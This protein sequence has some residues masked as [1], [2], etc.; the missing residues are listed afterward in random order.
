MT[1]TSSI[2]S[3]ELTKLLSSGIGS[4]SF[5]SYEGYS[6]DVML[7]ELC[8]PPSD[9]NNGP[10]SLSDLQATF[11]SAIEQLLAHRDVIS[12]KL[13]DVDKQNKKIAAKFHD[14]LREPEKLLHLISAEMDE[15]EYRFTKVSSSAVVI[16]DRLAIIDKEK[17][18][19]RETD[20]LLEAILLLNAPSTTTV[21]SST[22]Q[23]YTTLKD[24]H[25][26]HEALG[27][28][29]KLRDFADELSS[30][31]TAVAV[32]EIHR[33]NQALETALLQGFSDAQDQ[34]L[35]GVANSQ[36]MDAMK[37]NAASLLAH[38][39]NDLVADRFVWNV[40]KEKLTKHA[41]FLRADDS[42]A[43]LPASSHPSD[44][45]LQDLDSLTAKVRAIV[46]SQ[47]AVIHRV[48]PGAVA[49]SVREVLIERVC[50]DPAF[51]LLSHLERLLGGNGMSDKEYVATLSV[52]Y[53][54]CCGLVQSIGSFPLDTPAESDR[55]RTFLTVQLQVLFGGHR[56]RYVQIEQDLLGQGFDK[57][58]SMIKWPPIPSGKNKYKLKEQAAKETAK[59]HQITSPTSGNIPSNTT[60]LTSP[61]S[62]T[63][64]AS[65]RDAAPAN[66]PEPLNLFY[67]MLLPISMDDTMPRK[68]G[69]DLQESTARCDVVLRNSELRVELMARLYTSYCHAFGDEYL[70]KMANLSHELVQEP[71]LCLESASNFFVVNGL[72]KGDFV[73]NKQVQTQS[74]ACTQVVQYL[75][76][77][78][79]HACAALDDVGGVSNRTQFVSNV[80]ATFKD[81][82]IAH[83]QKFKFD[84]DGACLLLTDLA[85]YRQA[86][87]V[88]RHPSIDDHFDLLHAIANIYALPRDSLVSYVTEGLQTTLGKATL[89]AL[90]RR[91]WDYNLNGDK[92]PI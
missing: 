75:S 7:D 44:D 74:K 24:P 90:I 21:K 82:Y 35:R 16:G 62:T 73:G 1:S 64:L 39:C 84:A 67:Q 36:D 20:E 60:S 68:F 37:Q 66:K 31:S 46:K 80:C 79:M 86:F 61:A 41:Q 27:I 14:S 51:G 47:F 25:K 70:G 42:A 12:A 83:L 87:R 8:G 53:E 48:F 69:R 77:M 55:M 50:H 91:R 57:T 9:G 72:D 22:N 65:P 81:T 34:E 40:I 52:A 4:G 15:L 78:F 71:L 17:N 76:H 23:L 92:I 19:A 13:V 58:L 30:P 18:R 3:K 26:I 28:V 5:Q 10:S 54:K 88:C 43:D 11:K 32:Q 45:L 49:P 89:H 63:A 29:S 59:G 6:T 38:G 2:R 33:L 85:M 56:Q